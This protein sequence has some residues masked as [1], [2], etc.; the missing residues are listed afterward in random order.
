M[1][2]ETKEISF[3]DDVLD[4]IMSQREKRNESVMLA[5]DNE[6]DASQ[7]ETLFPA[8][9]TRR[10]TL[11]FKP[12]TPAGADSEKN[13]K[14]LAVRN[15]RGEHLGHLITVRGITTRVSDVKPAV[16]INAYTCDRCGCEIFQP[17]TTKQFLPLTEC[18]SEECKQNNSKGQL[19]LSTRASKFVPSRKLRSR[20]WPTKCL[21]GTSLEP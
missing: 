1:P 10:Y 4:I 6:L 5:A 3:K 2:K 18:P 17:V 13:T 11:V 16:Q 9:L 14:A 21:L 7:P 19:F 15:V 20:R 8:E 12:I